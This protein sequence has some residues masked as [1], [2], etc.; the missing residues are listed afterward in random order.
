LEKNKNPQDQDWDAFWGRD[1]ARKFSQPSWSKRRLMRLL[2]PFANSG[3]KVLDAGCGSGFFSAFFCSR[4]MKCVSLDYSDAALQMAREV[5][6]GRSE[7]FKKDLIALKDAR[8]I[9]GPFDLIFTDGLLEHFE[10]K[11]QNK[12]VQNLRNALSERGILVTVVPNRWSPWEII[13]PLFMPGI[14]ETPFV[15]KDLVAL[16][17]RNGLCVFQSGGLNTIPFIFSPDSFVGRWFG[18]LLF[19]VSKRNYE[20]S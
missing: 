1:A 19:T 9:N 12:I 3:K 2:A 17:E 20:Q 8:E 14:E 7:I 6:G 11:D 4:G 13:R 10:R 15:L 5:T 16:H 18:M